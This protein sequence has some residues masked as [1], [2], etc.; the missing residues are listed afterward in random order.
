MWEEAFQLF[1]RMRNADIE[2]N[3]VTWNT[4]A[5]GCLRTSNYKGALDLISQMR[6]RGVSLDIVSMIIGLGACSRI[7]CVKLRKEIHSYAIRNCYEEVG[8]FKNALNTMYSRCKD[9]RHAHVLFRLTKNKGVVTWNSMIAGYSNSDL[10]EK[11]PFYL[12][13]C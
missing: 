6:Y 3:I 5:C 2:A 7:G 8:N 11:P 9:L 10:S 1:E 13:R 12:G 4:I